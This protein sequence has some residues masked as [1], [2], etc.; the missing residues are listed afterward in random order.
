MTGRS[1]T[2]PRQTYAAGRP[3]TGVAPDSSGIVVAGPSATTTTAPGCCRARERER[4]PLRPAGP[5][6]R[7]L[8]RTVEHRLR[9]GQRPAGEPRRLLGEGRDGRERL[10]GGVAVAARA[11]EGGVRRQRV[12]HAESPDGDALSAGSRGRATSASASS[13][14]SKKPPSSAAEVLERRVEQHPRAVEPDRVAG[15]L[16]Q[17]RKPAA[18]Q[19]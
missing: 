11:G 7:D 4:V 14:V 15:G 17:G 19:P 5:D 2:K 18:T 16:Q 10:L 9:R 3:S 13:A 8:D 6:D 12:D 1:Q